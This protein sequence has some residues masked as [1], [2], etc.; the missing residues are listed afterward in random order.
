MPYGAKGKEVRV[1]RSPSSSDISPRAWT[2]QMFFDCKF[3]VCPPHE[4]ACRQVHTAPAKRALPQSRLERPLMCPYQTTYLEV[5]R[6][7]VLSG[8]S[9][10]GRTQGI[11]NQ[12]LKSEYCCYYSAS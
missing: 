7:A 5:Y 12:V 1:L 8:V 6:D 4:F 9:G 3:R 2:Q 10:Q 11:G